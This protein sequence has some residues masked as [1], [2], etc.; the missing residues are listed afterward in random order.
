MLLISK[1]AETEDQLPIFHTLRAPGMRE[2][3]WEI[4]NART[5]LS[6]APEP[7]LTLTKLLDM[8]VAQVRHVPISPPAPSLH[9]PTPP[10]LSTP[11]P[12]AHLH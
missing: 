8:G 12:I 5:G 4:L 9:P 6:L 11:R 10:H 7:S 2:R 3:H 1:L